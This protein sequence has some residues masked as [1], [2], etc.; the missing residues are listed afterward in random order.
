MSNVFVADL[1]MWLM[2]V[3]QHWKLS[4]PAEV[5]ALN[6]DHDAAGGADSFRQIR[7]SSL[8]CQKLDA[9][10][11]LGTC[12]LTA[13]LKFRA[14]YSMLLSRSDTRHFHCQPT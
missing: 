2:W 12:W 10:G 3:V 6:H 1:V 9:V 8:A 5:P 13:W 11:W 14:F 7:Y 4:I